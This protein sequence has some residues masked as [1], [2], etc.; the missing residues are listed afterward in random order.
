MGLIGFFKPTYCKGFG[1]EKYANN[2][3]GITN[4]PRNCISNI[5]R[6]NV[7]IFGLALVHLDIFPT[8]NMLIPVILERMDIPTNEKIIKIPIAIPKNNNNCIHT[9]LVLR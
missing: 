7:N 6:T 4:R 8:S 2:K 5:P 9:G 1:S 3:E